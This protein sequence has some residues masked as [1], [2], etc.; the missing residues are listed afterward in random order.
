MIGV[1][2]TAA[3]IIVL[4]HAARGQ[5]SDD[6][7]VRN[8]FIGTWKLV[9]AQETLRDGT[10]RP[11]KELGPHGQGYLIYSADGH[12]C[13]ELMNRDRPRWGDP[14]T[15]DQKVASVDGFVSYCGR[16]EIDAANHVMVHYPEVAWK[17]NYV[18]TKQSRPYTFEG[19]HLVYSAKTS[20][21]G[22][23]EVVQWRIEWEKV[24]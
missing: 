4:W 19:G 3:V 22:A 13:A 18:G 10:V 9:A 16:F 2:G 21:D 17:P 20:R 5:Q 24:K 23:P 8:R 1:M 11:Y 6:S 15:P 7:S 12:M 14:P